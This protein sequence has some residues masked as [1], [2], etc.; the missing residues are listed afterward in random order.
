M[1]RTVL[2]GGIAAVAVLAGTAGYLIYSGGGSGSGGA[3][4]PTMIQG[5][6]TANPVTVISDYTT[7]VS[8]DGKRL[9]LGFPSFELKAK[10]GETVTSVFSTSWN[11]RLPADERVVVA[12]ATVNGFMKSAAIPPAATPAPAAAPDAGAAPVPATEPAPPAASPDTPPA[13]VAPAAETPAPPAP[14]G[15]APGDGVVRLVVTV[16]GEATVTEWR[17]ATGTGL[18][19]RLSRAASL[20]AAE[21]DLRDGGLV[22]VTVTVE[23]AGGTAMETLAKMNSIDVQVFTE[24]APLPQPAAE[25]PTGEPAAPAPEAPAP[26]APSTDTPAEAPAT[27]P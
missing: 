22:P 21:K 12:T 13:E 10:A 27:N 9:S 14:V 15:P 17:D 18:N 16:A 4:A 1:N 11:I 23:V 20:L 5:P 7:N 2:I 6:V 3:G 26:E 8:Q 24:N 19:R 25:A